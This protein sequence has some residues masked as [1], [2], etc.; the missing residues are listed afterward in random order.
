MKNKKY[1]AWDKL[2]QSYAFEGFHVI[3]EVTVFG[4]IDML[5]LDTYQERVL[6][7]GHTD[8]IGMWDDFILEEYVKTDR[9]SGV[10]L[11]EG[12]IVKCDNGYIGEIYWDEEGCYFGILGFYNSRYDY[13]SM[14]FSENGSFVLL[15]NVNEG[16][17]NE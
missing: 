7:F 5:I 16:I 12:D 9:K 10:D 15:G 13:P 8:S 3:G 17:R 4:G 2:S 6:A 11:Y 14:P 1:R